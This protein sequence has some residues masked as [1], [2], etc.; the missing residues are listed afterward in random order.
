MRFR[1]RSLLVSS[2]LLV[3]LGLCAVLG[4]GSTRVAAAEGAPDTLSQQEPP[5]VREMVELRDATSKTYELQNGQVEWVTN[6]DVVNYQDADGVWREVDNRLVAETNEVDGIDYAYRNAAH[7]Y[8]ARFAREAGGACL[9]DVEYKGKSIAFGPTGAKQ[10]EGVTGLRIGSQ[11]LSNTTVADNALGYPDLF[12]QVDLVYAATGTG[13]KESVVLKDRSAQ[14]EFTFDFQLHGVTARESDGQITFVDDKGET[15][16]RLG[17]LTAIDGSGVATQD[18]RCRIEGADSEMRLTL[19]LSRAFLDDPTR[20]FPVV[21]DPTVEPIIITGANVMDTWVGSGTPTTTYGSDVNLRTGYYPGTGT[22]WTLI[23]FN[24][25]GASIDPG[26]IDHC[27]IRLKKANGDSPVMRAYPCTSWWESTTANWNNKP[28][29]AWDSEYQSTQAVDSGNGWWQMDSTYTV[30]KWLS[31][32]WGNCGW[33]LVDT[34]SSQQYATGFYS[35]NYGYPYRPELKI[36]YTPRT[37]AGFWAWSED[38][39]T[40]GVHGADHF[41]QGICSTLQAGSEFDSYVTKYEWE[42]KERQFHEAS[43]ADMSDRYGADDEAGEGFDSVDFGVFVDHGTFNNLTFPGNEHS[44]RLVDYLARWGNCDLE[45]AYVF[46]C[47]WFL[48]VSPEALW[49]D[50]ASMAGIHGICGFSTLYS[51][52]YTGGDPTPDPVASD[53]GAHYARYLRGLVYPYYV[54][55]FIDA[56]NSASDEWQP[57]GRT[58]VSMYAPEYRHEYLP[59]AG[60]WSDADPEPYV[61]GGVVNRLVYVCHDG[62]VH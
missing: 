28:G 2:I 21:I 51:M 13:V 22:R 11:A 60:G 26:W 27:Y 20:V 17:D 46:A 23:W 37:S 15:T 56:F 43:S 53:Q 32:A 52:H 41:A 24:L 33:T 18:I 25:T 5:R 57:D 4:V 59:D 61:D 10:S 48:A 47:E 14:N 30:K 58:A 8:T 44:T 12:P 3:A 16:F 42:C 54:R 55:D 39:L 50:Y 40:D 7:I 36:Y 19:T 35:A 1:I 29:V 9:V 6:G 38:I 62:I 34:R 45:W 49:Q 31:G